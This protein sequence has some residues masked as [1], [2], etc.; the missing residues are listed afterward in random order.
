MALSGFAVTGQ[1]VATVSNKSSVVG[2]NTTGSPTNLLVSN[3]SNSVIYVLLGAF[4]LALQFQRLMEFQL[5]LNHNS[6]LH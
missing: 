5:C 6:L 4:I 1:V 3:L 2:L